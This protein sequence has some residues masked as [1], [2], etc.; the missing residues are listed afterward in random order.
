[1][2]EETCFNCAF[3][4]NFI[5]KNENSCHFGT[6]INNISPCSN[7]E[8][9]HPIIKLS[10]NNRV[11]I[12]QAIGLIRDRPFDCAEA[13]MNI[14]GYTRSPKN[15]NLWLLRYKKHTLDLP[16]LSSSI[17]AFQQYCVTWI[18][19]MHLCDDKYPPWPN[20]VHYLKEWY[21][22]QSVNC[23]QEEWR[24]TEEQYI[25]NA[26]AEVRLAAFLAAFWRK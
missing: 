5:C 23:F 24:Y 17:G 19:S 7:F 2:C 22:E 10:E 20:Y 3:D 18:D 21:K 15:G 25:H 1:M 4:D 12:G 11:S 8:K 13:A 26:P 16:R 6:D 9:T 14:M